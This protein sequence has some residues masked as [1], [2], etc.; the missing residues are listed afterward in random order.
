MNDILLVHVPDGGE[1][2][3][4]DLDSFLFLNIAILQNERVKVSALAVL[5]DEVDVLFVVEDLIEPHDIRVVECLQNFQF[6]AQHVELLTHS[7]LRDGFDSKLAAL[8][9]LGGGEPDGPVASVPQDLSY[10]VEIAYVIAGCRLR[11]LLLL[12]VYLLLLIYR[13]DGLLQLPLDSFDLRGFG[14]EYL[15]CFI[16]RGLL[17]G[18]SSL[19]I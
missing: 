15:V 13:H 1:Y 6:S 3:L 12:V 9:L 19:L 10:D 14:I 17:V 7:F 16:L 8:L 4:D 2:F 5:H 11:G 18:G